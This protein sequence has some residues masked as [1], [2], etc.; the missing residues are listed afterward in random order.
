MAYEPKD[1]LWHSVSIRG[2]ERIIREII[3]WAITIVLVLLW[4]VPVVFL[5]SLVSIEMIERVAPS[6]AAH[7]KDNPIL[8]NVITSFVPTILINIVTSVLPM[9]FDGRLP[10]LNE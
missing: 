6:V 10:K 1:V 4:F 8:N 5:S 3:I 7:F 9:I 2:R